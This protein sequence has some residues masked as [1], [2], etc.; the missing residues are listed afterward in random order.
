MDAGSNTGI[1]ATMTAVAATVGDAPAGGEKTPL[2]QL[3]AAAASKASTSNKPTGAAQRRRWD[4]AAGATERADSP[5]RAAR[6]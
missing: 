2:R 4:A 6:I 3:Q 1:A 5:P